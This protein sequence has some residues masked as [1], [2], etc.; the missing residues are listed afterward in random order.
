MNYIHKDS[1]IKILQNCFLVPLETHEQQKAYV[2]W[3]QLN[4]RK[5]VTC[6]IVKNKEEN[7]N[8]IKKGHVMND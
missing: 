6:T 3:S 2:I 8:V 7:F 1:H 4:I 5:Y